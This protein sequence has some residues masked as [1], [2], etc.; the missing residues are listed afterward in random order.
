MAVGADPLPSVRKP[1]Q[2]MMTRL[3]GFM[4]T[5]LSSQKSDE[6]AFQLSLSLQYVCCCHAREA[7]EHRHGLLCG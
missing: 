2:T 1:C 7:V 5:S 4:L 6:V 3:H